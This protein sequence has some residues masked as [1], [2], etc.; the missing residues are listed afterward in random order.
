MKAHFLAALGVAM[1]TTVPRPIPR[2]PIPTGSAAGTTSK[3]MA[4]EEGHPLYS[5]FGGIHHICA[6]DKALEGSRSQ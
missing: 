4:I 2:S 6:N 3:S 5:A 1:T